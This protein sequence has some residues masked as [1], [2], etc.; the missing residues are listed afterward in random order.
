M[1]RRDTN[2]QSDI[3]GYFGETT[4]ILE[5]AVDSSRCSECRKLDLCSRKTGIFQP[6]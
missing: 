4:V 6:K 5:T 3:M 1:K 2:E